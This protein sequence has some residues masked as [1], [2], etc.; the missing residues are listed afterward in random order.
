MNVSKLISAPRIRGNTSIERKAT[1]TELF[2]DLAFVA[3]IAVL[4]HELAAHFDLKGIMTFLIV[5]TGLWWSWIGNTFYN[6]RFDTDDAVHR[7]MV[8]LQMVAIVLTAIFLHD[9]FGANFVPF[10][11]SFALIRLLIIQVNATA[12]YFNPSTRG[13]TYT[14]AIG[15][16]VALIPHFSAL[17]FQDEVLRMIL[18][19]LGIMISLIMPW[20]VS[21]DKMR[22]TPLNLHHLSERFGLFTILILGESIIATVNGG[23]H[24]HAHPIQIAAVIAGAIFMVFIFWWLYFE[25]LDGSVFKSGNLRYGQ[26]WVYTHLLL[27]MGLVFLSI[28]IGRS[29]EGMELLTTGVLFDNA[30]LLN[31]AWTFVLPSLSM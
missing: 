20:L 4:G 21:N 9:P 28:G 5:F 30:A 24:I 2:Y 3:S 12:G 15:F 1:W 16:T 18:V 25:K 14:Y 29:I 8:Y 19:G 7:F 23:S 26:I 27:M 31:I 17:L 13:V 6:D 11:F 10:I 22:S